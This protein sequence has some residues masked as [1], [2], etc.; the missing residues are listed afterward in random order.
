MTPAKATPS[1]VV[2]EN[3][4]H[5]T[6][7][8]SVQRLLGLILYK[9]CSKCNARALEVKHVQERGHVLQFTFRCSHCGNADRWDNSFMTVSTG[10]RAVKAEPENVMHVLAT[11]LCGGGFAAYEKLSVVTNQRYCS[12]STFRKIL[13]Q[14]STVT[15]VLAEREFERRVRELGGAYSLGWDCGWGHRNQSSTGTFVVVHL[16]TKKVLYVEPMVKMRTREVQGTQKVVG[17]HNYEGS[18][19]G[20]EAAGAN[21]FCTWFKR[22]AEQKGNDGL[23]ARWQCICADRD[24]TLRSIFTSALVGDTKTGPCAHVHFAS[25]PGHMRKNLTAE[26]MK[27]VKTGQRVVNLPKRI[28]RFFMGSLK[29]AVHDHK[30]MA[31]RK[32]QFNRDW[33][34]IGAHLSRATC[35]EADP[36][37]PCLQWVEE[38][39]KG[40]GG[41]YLP[42]VSDDETDDPDLKEWYREEDKD[43]EEG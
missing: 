8:V 34:K 19:K 15:K 23:L 14:L 40:L 30:D 36:Q 42:D 2:S 1:A 27:E 38:D 24:S 35:I 7:S 33:G 31:A 25:D 9:P 17:T 4:Q 20:M 5:S 29:R 37:C 12:K 32:E 28:G 10:V 26:L 22:Q 43:L 13:D 21:R 41:A 39:E 18:S 16:D 3:L 6:V 11:V